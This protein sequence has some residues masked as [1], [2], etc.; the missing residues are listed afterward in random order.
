MT[1]PTTAPQRTVPFSVGVCSIIRDA[2]ETIDGFISTLL[3]R[4]PAGDPA[5]D[6]LVLVDTGSVDQTRER[7]ASALNQAAALGLES[8]RAAPL[9]E[10]GP[11]AEA[12]CAEM[13]RQV[14]ARAPADAPF[15]VLLLGAGRGLFARALFALRPDAVLVAVDS[16]V[17]VVE[18]W[19]GLDVNP[20]SNAL[21]ICD[22]RQFLETHIADGGVS[23]EPYDFVVIDCYDGAYCDWRLFTLEAA[24]LIDGVLRE[25]PIGGGALDG[26]RIVI[27]YPR[28]AAAWNDSDDRALA[29]LAQRDVAT[30]SIGGNEIVVAPAPAFAPTIPCLR[31]ADLFRWPVEV[32]AEPLR[33]RV[34]GVDV[35]LARL[36]WPGDF[37]AARNFAFG[38]GTADW[39]GYFDAD[40]S[41][42]DA[43]LLRGH[44][45]RRVAEHSTANV[46][47]LSYDYSETVFQQDVERFFRWADGF[48]WKHALHEHAELP[49]GRG[50]HK[51]FSPANGGCTVFHARG[52]AR[53]DRS[54][55]R[56]RGMLEDLYA[57][58]KTVDDR[59]RWAFFLGEL[60][61]W[62]SDATR[63]KALLEEASDR[64]DSFGL[65]ALCARAKYALMVEKD[66][67]TALHYAGIAFARNPDQKMPLAF[68]AIAHVRNGDAARASHALAAYEAAVGPIE[69]NLYDKLVLEALLPLEAAKMY[70]TLGR[71]GDAERWLHRVDATIAD[72]P[73]A[74]QLCRRTFA[75]FERKRT[76]QVYADGARAAI[77]ATDPIF[78]L[79]M[80]DRAPVAFRGEAVIQTLRAEVAK[81]LEFLNSWE[82]F[83]A[84]YARAETPI[85]EDEPTREAFILTMHRTRV[86]ISWAA[87]RAASTTPIRALSIGP[88]A[89]IMERVALEQCPALSFTLATPTED[90]ERVLRR[91]FAKLPPERARFHRVA[92]GYFDWP[93]EQFDF[94][95]MCEVMEHLPFSRQEVLTQILSRLVP[96][97]VLLVSVPNPETM[98]ESY[99]ADMT[100]VP[101]FYAHISPNTADEL[102]RDF[103]AAG[104]DVSIVLGDG[105]RAISVTAVRQTQPR[106]AAPRI[107]IPCQAPKPFDVHSL[108]E[109]MLGGSEEAAVHLSHALAARGYEV[110]VFAPMPERDDPMAHQTVVSKNVQWRDIKTFT[111]AALTG[112]ILLAW[113]NPFLAGASRQMPKAQQ[114]LLALNWLHDV[115]YG[116]PPAAYEAV[117]ATIVLSKA[118]ALALQAGDGYAGPG[119]AFGANGIDIASLPAIPELD[120]AAPA[121]DPHAVIYG[122]SPDRGLDRLVAMWPQIRAAVPNATLHIYYGF[123]MFDARCAV[124]PDF[125]RE[126]QPWANA[127]KAAIL[128]LADQG[129]TFH[130][131]VSHAE[132]HLAYARCGVLAAPTSFYETSCCH[133]DTR[134]AMPGDHRLG[135]P[136]HP[137]IADLV[138]KSG[139]PV[140]AY[141]AEA[142]RF[143]LATVKWVAQTK[144]A[145][146]MVELE[147]DDGALLRVTP[148]HLVMNFDAEWIAA[149]D[150]R[151]GQRLMALH[152]RYAVS[153]KDVNGRWASESRLVG[154]WLEGRALRSDEHV[155]HLDPTRLDNRPES[156]QVLSASNHFR[157]THA[158]SGR[159]RQHVIDGRV[160]G[161][162]RWAAS[163]A[164]Q[165][166]LRER[167]ARNGKL[168]WERVNSLP[169][170]ER[171]SW[172]AERAAR[173][174][175]TVRARKASDPAYAEH[176]KTMAEAG[177]ARA[178]AATA[179]LSPDARAELS[180]RR[181]AAAWK[182][183]RE[184]Y[185]DAG[186]QNHHVV[187]VRRIPGGPVYD[188]EVEGLHNFVADGV[189]VH[190][191]I[192]AMKAQA[193]GCWP[194][195]TNVG[196]LPET[197]LRGDILETDRLIEGCG[198]DT[199]KVR[200][201]DTAPDRQWFAERVIERLLGRAPSAEQRIEMA[202]VARR[203]FSWGAAAAKFEAIIDAELAAKA[204]DAELTK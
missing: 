132:L 84:A 56:N 160:A 204:A 59:T 15:R 105:E 178:R 174:V 186:R 25:T 112:N 173:K 26:G 23:A 150:I 75:V 93:E 9:S 151:P 168:L 74:Q 14:A 34:A 51:V 146:E 195:M 161:F 159:A 1:A 128:A 197:V 190:N 175:A 64:T 60:T 20:H 41:C 3:S 47:C 115:A 167:S 80:L 55:G 10:I 201:L 107:V 16:A 199:V 32:G 13:A 61:L 118:H 106:K 44:I 18:H 7:I 153:I 111:P 139:F 124:D 101:D 149:G 40:D 85:I 129:V 45:E 37:A 134:I 187:A 156:L 83:A 82:D 91:V 95:A 46:V 164:G 177:L 200:D 158:N 4:T 113:R 125:A 185:G 68:I 189:V 188:M 144:I 180:A 130:G 2:R 27:N 77:I 11:E 137:R 148:D 117:D 29:A 79:E 71:L 103:R 191:C 140:Y 102:Y 78:A 22:A 17:N 163:E 179:S 52:D 97:G 87:S 131:G 135:L 53:A 181:T 58:A 72:D 123:A 98:C 67:E 12:Y 48:Q 203:A 147:L 122:S 157:K 70:S 198:T 154:E 94:I 5:F 28:P 21:T 120:A 127:L 69:S 42:P 6:E 90:S 141:D 30:I 76:A 19:F 108:D 43:G 109:G 138:G 143:K 196:A 169:P 66:N 145:E 152:Y 170:A 114:P 166:S 193:L 116:A 81:R 39:R 182:T 86:L 171:A 176:V 96:G 65:Y 136:P 192:T 92:K 8:L 50:K 36:E 57:N 49:P 110:E 99:L 100:K 155:D 89:G 126:R 33:Q 35:V 54:L 162:K 121:R 73:A 119:V 63:G 165:L 31:D 172:I 133:P 88:F 142:R 194:V 62:T 38:L 183:R 104:L 202:A 24:E 184:R